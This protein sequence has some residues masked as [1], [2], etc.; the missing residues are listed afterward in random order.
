MLV[1]RLHGISFWFDSDE[2]GEDDNSFAA[3]S[4]N[5]QAD[6]IND[7]ESWYPQAGAWLGK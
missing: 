6:A 2:R 3:A 1:A 7:F 4:I 5:D